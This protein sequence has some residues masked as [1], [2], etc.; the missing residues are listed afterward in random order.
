MAYQCISESVT[1]EGKYLNFFCQPNQ[2]HEQAASKQ[3]RH[4]WVDKGGI[5]V[6]Q[7]EN[8][9]TEGMSNAILYREAQKGRG[10]LEMA[11]RIQSPLS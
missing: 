11:D 2:R 8:H 1:A 10:C 5:H 6:N 3:Q 9:I 7:K 4:N